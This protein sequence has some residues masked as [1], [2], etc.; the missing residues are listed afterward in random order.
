M[1]TAIAGSGMLSFSIAL[2]AVSMHGACTVVFVVVGAIIAFLVSCVQTLDKIS[3]IGWVGVFSIVS[4]VITLAVACGVSDRPSAAPQTGPFEVI[5]KSVANPGFV[6]AINA[7]NIIIFAYAGTPC[8]F[9][10]VGEMR[11]V[12]DYT[13]S[14]LVCQSVVTTVYL[15]IG[16][17][18]YHYTGQYIASP[19]LGSAGILMKKVCYGLAMPGLL[20]G[21]IINSHMPAKYSK[22]IARLERPL[23]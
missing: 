18:V 7:L 13:K 10:I 2:N 8:F 19:A 12:K 4:S 6:D 17:V 21:C 5:V 14:V 20:V 15:V 23:S 11:N 16:S 9:N 1:L 22:R 3:W